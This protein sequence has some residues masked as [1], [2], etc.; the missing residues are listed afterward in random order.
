[1]TLASLYGNDM[2]T[3]DSDIKN[4]SFKHIYLLY[5]QESY[6][7]RGYRK[8]LTQALRPDDSDIN[9]THLK[10]SQCSESA[11][12][13]AADT[14]PFFAS[15]RLIVCE[16]GG[17][18]NK[19][20]PTLT[21]YIKSLPETAYLIFTE[22]KVDKRTSLYKA[23]QKHGD[24]EELNLPD[25]RALYGWISKRTKNANLS[26]NSQAWQM[27]YNRAGDSM[28][29]MSNE[30]DKLISYCQGQEAITEE[31]ISVCCPAV[32]EDRIFEML[33]FIAKKDSTGAMNAY[34]DLLLRKE[35]PLKIIAILRSQFIKLLVV[36]E[37]TDRRE[38][39]SVIARSAG[40]RPYFIRKNQ[41]LAGN[42]RMEELRQLI[43]DAGNVEARIKT[44]LIDPQIGVE[45]IMMKYSSRDN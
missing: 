6:L 16:D 42:F 10:D 11:I 26:M 34:R 18:F 31:D 14:M 2:R 5:G 8:T 22:K 29:R 45:I 38:P 12:I 25:E 24:V 27:F 20:C 41:M 21:E 37:M 19:K 39:D 33:E 40:I 17:L 1:M 32:A 7:I 43:K 3:I 35:E 4:K 9:I 28:D 44:G 23:V 15:S 13:E 30:I 36:K